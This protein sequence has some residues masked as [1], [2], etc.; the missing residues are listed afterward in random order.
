MQGVQLKAKRYNTGRASGFKILKSVGIALS[1]VA[2]LGKSRTKVEVVRRI[3]RESRVKYL[4]A[5]ER[6]KSRGRVLELQS[7][8]KPKSMQA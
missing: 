1:F 6:R 8:A 4:R 2:R 5:A 3:F 7:R